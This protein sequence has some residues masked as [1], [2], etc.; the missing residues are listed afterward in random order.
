MAAATSQAELNIFNVAISHVGH[1]AITSPGESPECLTH[2]PD[3]RDA[4]L[5]WYQ[6]SFA[7][8]TKTLVQISDGQGNAIAPL[9]HFLFLYAIPGTPTVL[10]TLDVPGMGTS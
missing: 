2:Y 3:V 1:R 9:D 6:W 8:I 4:A 5:S 7:K 10:R